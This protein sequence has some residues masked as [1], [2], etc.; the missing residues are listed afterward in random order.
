[1]CFLF[2]FTYKSFLSVSFSTV[3]SLRARK[4]SSLPVCALRGTSVQEVDHKASNSWIDRKQFNSTRLEKRKFKPK[5]P[6]HPAV[7]YI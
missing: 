5:V 6:S 2:S 3:L 4:A 7:E 1:M